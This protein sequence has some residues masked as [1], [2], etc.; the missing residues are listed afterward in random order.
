[1][2]F[3][4]L[5]GSSAAAPPPASQLLFPAAI[6]R[7]RPA[8]GIGTTTPKTALQVNGTITPSTDNAG[9]L[10]NSTYRWNAVYS[11]NGT[12][13]TS[14]ERLKTNISTLDASSSLT[15]ILALTP[16][17]FNWK[18]P[19]AGTST[20]FGFIAQQVQPILPNIVSVGSD[21]NHTLGL[22]Y[23]EI[24]PVLVSAV[25]VMY[26]ELQSLQAT[27]AG[28]AT[29]IATHRLNAE[30]LDASE[31][32]LGGT[33]LTQAQLA[34]LLAND[35]VAP[36]PQASDPSAQQT[37]ADDQSSTTAAPVTVST[38]AKDV[39]TSAEVATSTPDITV[40][41]STMSTDDATPVATSA[42]STA[43]SMATTTAATAASASQ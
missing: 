35:S 21:A 38:T 29:S 15:D 32:C 22:N 27:I 18:D 1:V 2:G 13:Q 30:E 33:C 16:V 39:T 36:A 8:I 23:T 9:T 11:T 43:N 20:N 14:D 12:I 24:I 31:L 37:S 17:S 26:Q 3:C 40:A 7:A 42:T 5:G 10:G 41:S 19:T 25:Q 6:P 4:L 28:F 34:A